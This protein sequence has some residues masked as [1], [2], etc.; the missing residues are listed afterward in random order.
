V[1]NISIDDIPFGSS[2]TAVV[3][4]EFLKEEAK[5]RN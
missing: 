5:D 3:G 2:N 4:T 1:V